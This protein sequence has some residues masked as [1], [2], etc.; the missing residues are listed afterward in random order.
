MSIQNEKMAAYEFLSCMGAEYY[1]A[2]IT[3]KCR[4]VLRQLCR[5]IEENKPADLDALYELSH[6]ATEQI[7]ELEEEFD[8]AGSE[9]DTIARECLADDF[10]YIAEAYGF[11]ADLEELIEPREW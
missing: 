6:A 11:E 1:P 2:E 10:E 3:E 8:E 9:I 7:N 4:E 5:D